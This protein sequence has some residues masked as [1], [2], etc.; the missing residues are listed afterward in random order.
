M[1]WAVEVVSVRVCLQSVY[2]IQ[3]WREQRQW[4]SARAVS[5]EELL[6]QSSLGEGQSDPLLPSSPSSHLL[7]FTRGSLIKHEHALL[8]KVHL[9]HSQLLGPSLPQSLEDLTRSKPEAFAT[10]LSQLCHPW[11]PLAGCRALGLLADGAV[12][13]CQNTP[14]SSSPARAWRCLSNCVFSGPLLVL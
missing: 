4:S 2:S 12:G 7:H 6:T 3:S 8:C 9:M 1:C 14:S 13:C 11:M 5:S 10:L